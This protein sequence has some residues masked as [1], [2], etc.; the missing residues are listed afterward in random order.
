[1][2]PVDLAIGLGFIAF[3]AIGVVR[4]PDVTAGTMLVA[5][6]L[7][8]ALGEALPHS[9]TPGGLA[10]LELLICALMFGFW[11]RC[12][13]RSQRARL[14]GFTCLVK[15]G[16]TILISMQAGA[17]WHGFAIAFNALLAFQIAVAGGMADGVVAFAGRVLPGDAGGGGLGHRNVEA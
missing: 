3:A 13:W 16:L 9:R 12:D 6:V 4:R 2:A 1:M 7:G 11:Q 14:V 10:A 8:I 17:G 15:I 5:V